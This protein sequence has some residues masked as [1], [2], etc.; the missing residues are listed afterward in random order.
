MSKIR[1]GSSFL[2][3]L[4]GYGAALGG[5]GLGAAA[6]MVDA[7]ELQVL[8]GVIALGGLLIAVAGG[9]LAALG[10]LPGLGRKRAAAPT[11]SPEQQQLRD[12][13]EFLNR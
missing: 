2:L 8:F 7:G 5:L 1:S 4:V 3:K 6:L 13:Q 11:L 9:V 12:S 10:A